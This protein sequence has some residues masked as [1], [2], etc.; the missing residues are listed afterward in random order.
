MK[1]T[2]KQERFCQEY[3]VDF[4]ATQAAIR[5]GYSQKTARDIACENLAK[6][7][8][9]NRIKELT[10]QLQKKTD[11]TREMIIAEYAKIAFTDI[12]DY[13]DENNR[14]LS[15]K[16]LSDKSAAALAGI[17]IDE[18]WGASMDG[19]IQIGETKKIKRWDK[20]KALEGLSKVYGYYAAEKSEVKIDSA[21]LNDSQVKEIISEIRANAKRN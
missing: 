7:N 6:P 2:A 4:N 1:L 18:L 13:Y 12:R 14:L 9:E 5:A 21:P 20:L 3:I 16:E 19:K 8:I 17:E 15:V 10:S 11:I